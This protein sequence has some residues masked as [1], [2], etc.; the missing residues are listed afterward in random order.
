MLATRF[1]NFHLRSQYNFVL[2]VVVHACSLFASMASKPHVME[3]K[4]EV[5]AV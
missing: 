3:V 1:E 2:F 4:T 5:R